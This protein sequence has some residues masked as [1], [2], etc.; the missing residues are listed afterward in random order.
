MNSAACYPMQG[1]SPLTKIAATK[2]KEVNMKEDVCCK[3]AVQVTGKATG[4]DLT[5]RFTEHTALLLVILTSNST[6]G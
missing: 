6:V 5:D 1:L 4:R 3:D 2:G